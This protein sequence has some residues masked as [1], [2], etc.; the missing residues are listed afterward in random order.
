[1][2]PSTGSIIVFSDEAISCHRMAMIDRGSWVSGIAI[3]AFRS[4]RDDS[5]AI[6]SHC[7]TRRC[8]I[9]RGDSLFDD[10]QKLLDGHAV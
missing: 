10:G 2:P 7:P 4:L 9:H 8:G 6:P 1:M 5:W 3:V